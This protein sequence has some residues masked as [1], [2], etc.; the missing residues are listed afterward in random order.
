MRNANTHARQFGTDEIEFTKTAA[1]WKKACAKGFDVGAACETRPYACSGG[2][3]T[4][5]LSRDVVSGR[6]L[7]L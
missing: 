6:M 1:A 3:I 2:A 4:E 7:F 5:C